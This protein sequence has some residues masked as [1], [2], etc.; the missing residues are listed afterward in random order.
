MGRPSTHLRVTYLTST[1]TLLLF[2]GHRAVCAQTGA[3]TSASTPALTGGLDRILVALGILLVL[4]LATERVVVVL[5]K[6]LVRM[7]LD[8][9]RP[10]AEEAPPGSREKVDRALVINAFLAVPA[11]LFVALLCGV[12]VIYLAITGDVALIWHFRDW[13]RLQWLQHLLGLLLT[14]LIASMGSALLHDLI[15]IVAA[16]KD[17]RRKAAAAP[18]TTFPIPPP[19]TE[20]LRK[21]LDDNHPSIYDID[22]ESLGLPL[23]VLGRHAADV[24]KQLG[25]QGIE[26]IVGVGPAYKQRGGRR[27]RVRGLT[28][29][30]VTKQ[31][32]PHAS[33]PRYWPVP[34][35]AGETLVPLD[36][37]EV[38]EPR[39][40]SHLHPGAAI[41]GRPHDTEFK[42]PGSLCLFVTRS[43]EDPKPLLLSCHH[44]LGGRGR[45]V[46]VENTRIGEVL[47]ACPRWDA[48]VA[49]FGGSR[50][51][52]LEPINV[53]HAGERPTRIRRLRDN[54]IWE[55]EFSFYG[56]NGPHDR[57][58]K[59]T[60][61]YRESRASVPLPDAILAKL[62][63]AGGDSGGL[64]VVIDR[65]E[66]EIE[67]VAV[68]M[69]W[70]GCTDTGF[71]WFIPLDEVRKALHLEVSGASHI[72]I[73]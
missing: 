11:G 37:Q 15:A 21:L 62:S 46:L 50:A 39:P 52:L 24:A 56:R 36:L 58:R 44:V 71:A 60:L 14:G 31:K 5:R 59:G 48:S 66:Y 2:L 13:D 73:T 26:G 41:S 16:A 1:A 49:S 18:P 61:C 40:F 54:E 70:G 69:L 65:I 42:E 17:A 9:A 64:A 7:G 10:S 72:S 23:D 35:E 43:D 25:A 38:G 57:P 47:H 4:A 28:I 3:D 53:T 45:P 30:I 68:G 67:Y 22:R 19:P 32:K 20:D 55:R 51:D 6:L 27:T 12:D 8:W 29:S 63:A 34:S 33:A